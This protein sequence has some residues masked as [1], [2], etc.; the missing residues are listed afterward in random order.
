[1]KKEQPEKIG[2]NCINWKKWGKGK[3]KPENLEH[4]VRGGSTVIDWMVRQASARIGHLSED[5]K[6]ERKYQRYLQ[7]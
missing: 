5:L 6:E 3:E 2:Y 4:K 7:L 1:M